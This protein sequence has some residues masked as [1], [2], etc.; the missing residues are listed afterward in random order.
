M[1]VAEQ[2]VFNIFFLSCTV[3]GKS[4]LANLK[5]QTVLHYFN[6]KKPVYDAKFSPDGRYDQCVS[7]M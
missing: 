5:M 3:D 2:T 6:F 1:C 4:L 7:L